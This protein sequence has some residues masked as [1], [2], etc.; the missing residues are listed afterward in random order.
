MRAY[1]TYTP[2]DTAITAFSRRTQLKKR[3]RLFRGFAHANAVPIPCIFP[4][5]TFPFWLRCID[6]LFFHVRMQLVHAIAL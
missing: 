5:S 3:K 2:N 4:A 1:D 6:V